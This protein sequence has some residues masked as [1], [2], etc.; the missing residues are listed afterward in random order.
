MMSKDNP[1]DDR[2]ENEKI[3][4]VMRFYFAVSLQDGFTRF[5]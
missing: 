1:I 4:C 2:R 5:A 3:D